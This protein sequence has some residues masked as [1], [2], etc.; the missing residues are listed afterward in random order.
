VRF[1]GA[2]ELA[3]EEKARSGLAAPKHLQKL[4]LFFE[5]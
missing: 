2:I 1:G 4:G 3:G 5:R